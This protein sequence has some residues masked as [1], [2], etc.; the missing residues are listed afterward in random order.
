MQRNRKNMA[1][2]EKTQQS[3]ETDSEMTHMIDLIKI[4]SAKKKSG[5]LISCS[6]WTS[7]VSK[8]REN[9]NYAQDDVESMKTYKLWK[10]KTTIS[11]MKNNPGGINSRLD[12]AEVEGMDR[13]KK[14]CNMEHRRKDTMGERKEEKTMGQY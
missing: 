14:A 4:K 3:I 2:N 6:K 7:Y 5:M 13:T 1:H 10:L 12:R 8:S 11:E 9:C